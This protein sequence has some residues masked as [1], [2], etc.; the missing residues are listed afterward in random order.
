[1]NWIL[2]K[3][4]YSLGKTKLLN[5]VWKI[6][7]KVFKRL[8]WDM[9]ELVHDAEAEIP[10]LGGAAKAKLVIER[11]IADHDE[12]KEWRWLT[13]ILLEIAVG[14]AKKYQDEV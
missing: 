9:L 11:F 14:E 10:K 7:R 12:A 2:E 6:F 8:Y 1:M 13:N 5:I 4:L 3:V